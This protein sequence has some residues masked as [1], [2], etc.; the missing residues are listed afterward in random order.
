MQRYP[1]GI[2]FVN[3]IFSARGASLR[4]GEDERGMGLSDPSGMRTMGL[5]SFAYT[6]DYLGKAQQVIDD[7]PLLAWGRRAGITPASAQEEAVRAGIV[8]VR[9]V[10]N[11][12]AL[13][14]EEQARICASRVF[15]CGLGGLGGILIELLARMG[16]G[17]LRVADGDCF[18]ASNLNRQVLCRVEDLGKPK[19]L[20]AKE[21]LM[22][23]NPLVEV[24]AAPGSLTSEN[25]VQLVSGVDLAMDALDNIEGRFVLEQACGEL[26]IAL[27]HAA[28]AGWW[29]QISTFMP[30]SVHDL[31]AVYGAR[32]QKD[33]FEDAA[34]ILGPC[35]A[36]MGSLG[37]LE[38]ARIL[39]GRPPAYAGRLVY[40][41]GETGIMVSTPIG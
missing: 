10:R 9:Y 11:L 28:V 5:G 23:V 6:I 32:R 3:G 30:G 4:A 22:A 35:A 19:A 1:P 17:R 39:A 27:V 16:V 18:A 7:E 2:I 25:A 14:I 38:A 31:S 41:D 36:L 8:P 29:G 26:G 13:N 34:G 21:R 40:F 12:F 20:A 15:V 33:A 24:E 37:A